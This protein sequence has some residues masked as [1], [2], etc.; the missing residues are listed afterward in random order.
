LPSKSPAKARSLARRKPAL[1]DQAK[2]AKL[3]ERILD[4]VL[5]K[6]QDKALDKV[7][8]PAPNPTTAREED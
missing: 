6:V 3:P 4:R 5:D 8:R 2:A 7:L 1:R